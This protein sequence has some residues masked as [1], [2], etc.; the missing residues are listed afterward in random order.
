M[1]ATDRGRTYDPVAAVLDSI[2]RHPNIDPTFRQAV[3]VNPAKFNIGDEVWYR[4]SWGRKPPVLGVITGTGFEKGKRVYDVDLDVPE[5]RT[6]CK[7][8]YEDQFEAAQ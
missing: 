1:S 2:A 7:W 5:E 4:P 3:S 8:G 6:R